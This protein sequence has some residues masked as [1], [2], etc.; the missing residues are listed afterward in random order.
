MGVDG[1][2]H[3]VHSAHAALSQTP[4]DLIPAGE[5]RSLG[6]GR[7]NERLGTR[8]YRRKGAREPWTLDPGPRRIVGPLGHPVMHEIEHAGRRGVGEERLNLLLQFLV[9]AT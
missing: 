4:F 2:A 7:T 6:D 5:N 8:T 9:A 1:V 3:A